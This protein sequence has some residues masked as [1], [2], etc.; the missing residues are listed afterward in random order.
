MAAHRR[1]DSTGC[2]RR[3]SRLEQRSATLTDRPSRRA[4]G[5]DRAAGGA[6][7]VRRRDRPGRPDHRRRCPW[8][9]RRPSVV[10]DA[11]LAILVDG[12]WNAGA[13]AIAI[14]GQRLTALTPI[15]NAGPAIQVN[16]TPL[17]PPYVV[18]RSATR[19]H[20]AGQP[21]RHHPRPGVVRPQ[22]TASASLPDRAG[23][24]RSRCRPPGCA[25]CVRCATRRRPGLT[26]PGQDLPKGR[27]AMIAP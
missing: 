2:A 11:D 24:C 13:E 5:P 22:P 16:S 18:W 10:R 21:A 27:R 4:G 1:R 19:R 6:D 9:R 17:V 20:S 3:T 15:R 12:L 23:R 26:R 25:G 8:R 14:N 7:R